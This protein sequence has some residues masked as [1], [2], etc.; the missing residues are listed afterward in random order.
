ML[1]GSQVRLRP[2]TAKDSALLFEWYQDPELV[3]PFDRY[4]PDTLDAFAAGLAV[5][6]EDPASLYPRYT[7]DLR[8]SG[9][10]VGCVGWYRA[11]PVLEY[12][13]VWYVLGDPAQ[14][15]KGLG[16]EAVELLVTELFRT[17]TVQR[18]GATCD[19]E[20]VPSARLLDRIGFRREG[21]LCSALFHHARWHDVYVYGVTRSE[22]PPPPKA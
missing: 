13:D 10:T 11:H 6:A 20:N 7:V 22:W 17:Q 9:A 18:I 16:R 5:A 1:E 21:T 4:E 14:R 19:V 8:A 3:A 12:I 15:G 2:P